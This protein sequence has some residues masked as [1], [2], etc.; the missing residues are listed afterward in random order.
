MP[1]DDRTAL[2]AVHA[3]ERL[4]KRLRCGTDFGLCFKPFAKLKG[5][6]MRGKAIA[7]GTFGFA[8]EQARRACG[9]GGNDKATA[10][11][12][13]KISSKLAKGEQRQ[14]RRCQIESRVAL[15]GT[16]Q[17]VDNA[18][19]SGVLDEPHVP[20]VRAQYPRTQA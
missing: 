17:G 8:A 4:R 7:E 10:R 2:G 11:G 6:G 15:Y 16:A 18:V 1:G 14:E 12:L 9:I 5:E 19:V 13:R 20:P 3:D